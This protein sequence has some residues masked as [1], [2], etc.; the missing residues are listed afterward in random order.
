MFAGSAGCR[1]VAHIHRVRKSW[2]RGPHRIRITSKPNQIVATVT[3]DPRSAPRSAF[4]ENEIS[5]QRGGGGAVMLS[6]LQD[7]LVDDVS[8]RITACAIGRWHV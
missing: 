2:G 6:N 5:G 4:T 7:A 3:I 8:G 1:A